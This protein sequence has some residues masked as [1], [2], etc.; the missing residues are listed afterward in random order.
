MRINR[1]QLRNLIKEVL[2]QQ[3][4][5]GMLTLQ[6]LKA[7]DHYADFQKWASDRNVMHYT[8]ITDRT[9]A[10]KQ[11][12]KLQRMELVKIKHLGADIYHFRLTPAGKTALKS[13]TI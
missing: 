12:E 13:T 3:P 1:Q 6:F 9:W 11:A 10:L 5:L 8:G 2:Q 7:V 4:R